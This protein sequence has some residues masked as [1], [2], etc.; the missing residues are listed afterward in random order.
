VKLNTVKLLLPMVAVAIQS[1][2]ATTVIPPFLD[3]LRMPV[4]L[5]G[6]LI[7]LGPIFALAA[8][9]PVGM[10]YNRSSARL[11]IA[12]SVL[13]MGVTN[14]LYGYAFNSWSFAVIHCINGFAYSAVTTLYMAFY[15]DSL[16]PDAAR[17]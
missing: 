11:L 8:R 13:A 15:V 4:A 17:V 9:L 10:A 3:H 1:N 16:G 14:F 5:I 6:I 12:L 7:S 2:S